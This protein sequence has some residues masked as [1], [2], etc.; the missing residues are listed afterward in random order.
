MTFRQTVEQAAVKA[1]LSCKNSVA[2]NG[3]LLLAW[4]MVE[5]GSTK[6]P[7]RAVPVLSD[8]ARCCGHPISTGSFRWYATMLRKDRA[9]VDRVV[10]VPAAYEQLLVREAAL[11]GAC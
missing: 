1:N 9:T 3:Y 4:A 2:A 8:V 11:T 7:F 5:H 6:L 10:T